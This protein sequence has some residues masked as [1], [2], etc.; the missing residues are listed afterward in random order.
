MPYKI[1]VSRANGREE[2]WVEPPDKWQLTLPELVDGLC[3]EFF[4][5]RTDDAEPLPEH[6][7]AK[8]VIDI[9]VAEYSRYGT[10]ATWTWAE[11]SPNVDEQEARAWARD[12]I[13]RVLPGLAT[14]KES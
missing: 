7:T 6:L 11:Q 1:R 13:L 14:E 9:A 4:R 10:N 8:Q 2:R 5:D 3:S 12:M